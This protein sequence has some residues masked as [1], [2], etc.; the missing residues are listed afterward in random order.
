MAKNDI[1][2]PLSSLSRRRVKAD[3]TSRPANN[4]FILQRRNTK[5]SAR[6][7]RRYPKPSRRQPFTNQ[8]H[9]CTPRSCTIS[10]GARTGA[11]GGA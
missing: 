4:L 5:C 11:P 2:L 7:A 6:H 10:I 9:W 1:I 3:K 8:S